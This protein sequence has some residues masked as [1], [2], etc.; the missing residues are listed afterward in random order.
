VQGWEEGPKGQEWRGNGVEEGD[1]DVDEGDEEEEL[2]TRN[3]IKSNSE[4]LIR[5]SVYKKKLTEK[6]NSEAALSRQASRS[7]K[8][9]AVERL[10][11]GTASTMAKHREIYETSADGTIHTHRA[12][13]SPNVR[14]HQGRKPKRRGPSGTSPM[15]SHHMS[16][17]SLSTAGTSAFPR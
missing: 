9:K 6:L 10:L 16:S 7:A 2:F 15:S 17:P 14:L 5:H 11:G 1:D 3:L 12:H 8:S 13:G 4:K